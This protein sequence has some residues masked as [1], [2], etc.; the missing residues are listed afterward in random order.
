MSANP[1]NDQSVAPKATNKPI[2]YVTIE[3]ASVPFSI[4]LWAEATSN[5]EN[6]NGFNEMAKANPERLKQIIQQQLLDA[7]FTIEVKGI[8]TQ[9]ESNGIWD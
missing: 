8:K 6:R 2:G 5:N 7:N 9:I 3:I 1:F 4:E